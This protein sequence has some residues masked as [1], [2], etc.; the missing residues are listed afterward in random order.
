[1]SRNRTDSAVGFPS[2]CGI[3]LVQTA[4]NAELENV[5]MEH[6]QVKINL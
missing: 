2:S 6:V 3:V 5:S 1:M 4:I